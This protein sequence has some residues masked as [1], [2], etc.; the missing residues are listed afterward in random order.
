M[1]SAHDTTLKLA[2][3][4]VSG[5]VNA[6]KKKKKMQC[7]RKFLL[8]N[9]NCWF[10]SFPSALFT[11]SA[12]DVDAHKSSLLLR[13][14]TAHWVHKQRQKLTWQLTDNIVCKNVCCLQGNATK[15]SHWNPHIYSVSGHWPQNT[16]CPNTPAISLLAQRSFRLLGTCRE[17][18]CFSN[19]DAKNKTSK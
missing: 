13:N 18:V 16:D 17:Q 10:L 11:D 15:P 14:C 5:S 6:A 1:F 3:G 19:H 2:W 4:P 7:K 9:W 8:T 12:V